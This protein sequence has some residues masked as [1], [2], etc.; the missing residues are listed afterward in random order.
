MVIKTTAS[1]SNRPEKAFAGIGSASSAGT[2]PRSGLRRNGAL[3]V[4]IAP[5]SCERSAART[6]DG[7]AFAGGVRFTEG[8]SAVCAAL[9]GGGVR[10]CTLSAADAEFS[11]AGEAGRLGAGFPERAE[12]PCEAGR[13]SGCAN[14]RCPSS[15]ARVARGTLG[16]RVGMGL[17]AQASLF[18][19]LS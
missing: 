3:A 15:R 4:R 1:A 14:S 19:R 9:D 16:R 7:E 11:V 10:L 18:C 13:F 17:L 6:S 12:A 5:A 8:T 2:I